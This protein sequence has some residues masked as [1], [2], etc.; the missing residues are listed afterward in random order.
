MPVRRR[1]WTPSSGSSWRWS[2]W[3]AIIAFVMSRSGAR[4]VE[5]ERAQA[6]EIREK[7]V[8]H[9]R[10]LR[11]SEASAT[12]ASARSEMARAE[13]QKR[14]LEAERLAAE[15]DSRSESAEAVRRERDEQLRLAD[16]RDP[17]VQTDKDGHRLDEGGDRD[18]QGSLEGRGDVRDGGVDTLR[19]RRH[20]RPAWS[21]TRLATDGPVRG[22]PVRARATAGPPRHT[23]GRATASG[24][25]PR[26]PATLRP[27]STDATPRPGR[28]GCGAQLGQLAARALEPA[29]RGLG[30]A[31][32][33]PRP[34]SSRGIRGRRRPSSQVCT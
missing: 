27:A 29:S 7:A 18:G 23:T 20:P 9:D 4:R 33:P 26:R 22:P 28:R 1:P 30:C 34:R 5:A 12:E 25:R 16:L 19:A 6:A 14:E 24:R 10:R 15:A 17:D 8:E 2:S 11:E 32:T 3:A 31:T 13:A 21:R